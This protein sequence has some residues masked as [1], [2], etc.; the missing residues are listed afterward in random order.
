MHCPKIV[1][2]L[3]TKY[4]LM[5]HKYITKHKHIVH[6]TKTNFVQKTFYFHQKILVFLR[7]TLCKSEFGF[8]SKHV[9]NTKRRSIGNKKLIN[10]KHPECCLGKEK[11]KKKKVT[12]AKRTIT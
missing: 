7:N 5:V 3:F 9:T 4:K 8:Q 11:K 12:P 6:K 1:G 2:I 10:K